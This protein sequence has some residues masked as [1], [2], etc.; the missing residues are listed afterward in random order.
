[1]LGQV[2]SV[3]PAQR[4]ISTERDKLYYVGEGGRMD[5][6]HLCSNIMPCVM[7]INKFDK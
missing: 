3:P 4:T 5:F 6:M 1:M 2:V 7:A